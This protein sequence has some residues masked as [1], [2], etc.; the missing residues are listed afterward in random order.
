MFERRWAWALMEQ[1]L[2]RLR[3]EYEAA[4][5][6]AIFDELRPFLTCEDKTRGADA[7]RRLEMT[8]NNLKVTVHRLRHRYGEVLR[9]EMARTGATPEQVEEE[10]QD[11]FA[12]LG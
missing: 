6:A 5:K 9:E 8:E 12:A 10:I 1:G 2:N 7:A 3:E 11:L 4:G